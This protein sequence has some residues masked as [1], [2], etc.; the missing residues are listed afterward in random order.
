MQDTEK[1]HWQ[2]LV[3]LTK[4]YW[5]EVII[6]FLFVTAVFAIGVALF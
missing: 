1:Q 5:V 4:E 6:F 2:E 3:R